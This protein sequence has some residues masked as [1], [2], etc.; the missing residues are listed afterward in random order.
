[1]KPYVRPEPVWW[2]LQSKAYVL[3]VLRELTSVFIAAYVVLVLRLLQQ[4][5][6]GPAAYERYLRWLASPWLVSFQAV[7][8]IAAIYHSVTWLRLTPMT[9]V[10]RVRGRRVPA[11]VIVT[12]NVV[13]W[14]ALSVLMVWLAGRV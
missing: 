12:T 4:V 3:F 2:W 5:A 13:V 6:A 7:A 1:V 9:V 10:V 8:L 11:P 14:A